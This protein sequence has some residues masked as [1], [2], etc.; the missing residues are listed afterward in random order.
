MNATADL[1]LVLSALLDKRIVHFAENDDGEQGIIFV[2]RKGT[3]AAGHKFNAER[4][5][6]M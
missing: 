5:Q 2:G 3:C 1:A 4:T 6:K